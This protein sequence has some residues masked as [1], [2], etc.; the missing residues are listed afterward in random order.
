VVSIALASPAI[1]HDLIKFVN[2][3]QTSWVAGP[4]Q[5]FPQ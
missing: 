3:K 4:N 5:F 2:V 1:N